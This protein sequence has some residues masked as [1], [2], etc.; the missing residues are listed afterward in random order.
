[1][2]RRSFEIAAERERLRAAR[3]GTVLS[4]AYLDIDHFKSAN[5][6]LGHHA[7]DKVLEEVAGAISRAVRGT[8][9]FARVGGDEFVLLLPETDARESM[10]VAQRVRSAAAAAAR[11]AGYPV[12]LSAGIATFHYPPESVDAMLAAADSLLYKAKAAG[13]DRVVGAVMA[14]PWPRWAAA[15]LAPD[16]RPLAPVR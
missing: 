10:T 16:T 1:M 13:R 14:G 6:R 11:R 3:H 15:A 2:N 5:D 7:G 8:D 12:A 9:L 4:L